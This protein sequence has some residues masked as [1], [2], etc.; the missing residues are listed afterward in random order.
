M[1]FPSPRPDRVSWTH[2]MTEKFESRQADRQGGSQRGEG[3]LARAKLIRSHGFIISSDTHPIWI[4]QS[5]A[6]LLAARCS[7]ERQPSRGSSPANCSQVRVTIE[8]ILGIPF[9][10]PCRIFHCLLQK[11]PL[12]RLERNFVIPFAVESPLA[13][14]RS[15]CVLFRFA[16]EPG[17]VP[18]FLVRSRCNSVRRQDQ[19]S[20]HSFVT[21]SP[22][23]FVASIE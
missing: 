23:I 3:W 20:E 21:T 8:S 1:R 6:P 5:R 14:A 18:P 11:E 13:I 22:E 12:T 16:Q 7:T 2:P 19:S 10:F 4:N 15:M 9:C 17:L